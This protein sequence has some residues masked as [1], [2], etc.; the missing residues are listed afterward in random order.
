MPFRRNR[1]RTTLGK[2][3]EQ[4]SGTKM[5]TIGPGTVTVANHVIRDAQVGAR[6]P[7]GAN[8]TIQL[9]RSLEQECNIGDVVKY[10][11][12]FI[13]AGPRTLSAATSTGWL[14]W[15]FCTH[16]VSDT[17]PTNA[18]LGISTIGD[19]CTKYFRNECVMTGNLPVG[20]GQPN[21][22]NIIIKVPKS[23]QA[24]KIGDQY[25]LYMYYRTVSATET[26]TSTAR[27]VTS[28]IYRN[29]H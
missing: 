9:G 14:E 8:D 27:I 10:V 13:Q 20:S 29:Y 18:N 19:V 21:S 25:I 2:A 12:I 26:G 24:L 28:Y 15:A 11:N 4:H 23:K 1:K 6:D 17:A 22:H 3:S 16:K 5:H 7:A